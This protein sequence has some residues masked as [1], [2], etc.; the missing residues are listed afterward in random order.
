MTSSGAPQNTDSIHRIAAAPGKKD[1]ILPANALTRPRP[2]LLDPLREALRSRH[3]SRRSWQNYCHWVK[4]FIVTM[5][6]ESLKRPLQALLRK[7]KAIYERDLHQSPRPRA[8]WC[9]Q[10]RRSVMM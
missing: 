9:S 4:R 7:V 10:L 5:L 1:R 3:Y 6:P 8:D 2:K